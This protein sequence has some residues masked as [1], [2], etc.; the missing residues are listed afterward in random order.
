MSDYNITLEKMKHYLSVVHDRDDE[1]IKFLIQVALED[2]QNA[3]DRR[4]DDNTTWG[5]C[6]FS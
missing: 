3:I 1:F 6:T 5:E 4:F 2:V